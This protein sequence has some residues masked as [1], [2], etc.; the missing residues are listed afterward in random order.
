MYDGYVISE[1]WN[2]MFILKRE[3]EKIAFLKL[4]C[5]RNSTADD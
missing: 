4:L 5:E 2:K 3:E 1:F